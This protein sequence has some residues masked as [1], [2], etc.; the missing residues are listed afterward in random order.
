MKSYPELVK[1]KLDSSI[2]SISQYAWL[3]AKD[4]KRDFTRSRKLPFEEMIR[5]LLGM[6]GGNLTKE[7]L[8]VLLTG[9][10]KA[11]F[12]SVGR[13]SFDPRFCH[14]LSKIHPLFPINSAGMS[15]EERTSLLFISLSY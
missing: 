1:K 7:L 13:E 9:L 14:A 3:F 11:Y 10:R 4:P 8:L 12:P 2:H 5:I 15:D 6:G